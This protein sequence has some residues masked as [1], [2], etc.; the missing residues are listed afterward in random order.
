M[1][2]TSLQSEGRHLDLRLAKGNLVNV[3]SSAYVLG[4]F[5][6][7]NPTGATRF[8]DRMMG[9]TLM[10]LVQDGMLGSRLGEVSILPTSKERLLADMVIFVGLGPIDGFDSRVLE[11]VAE[12]LARVVSAA[13]LSSCTVVP[14]GSNA[15]LKPEESIESFLTGFLRGLATS[16]P[17]HEFQTLQFCERE[18]DRYGRLNGHV[19]ELLARGFFRDKGVDISVHQTT[20]DDQPEDVPSPHV[21][22]RQLD[23]LYL[24]VRTRKD[25]AGNSALDYC[26]LTADFGPT[27]QTFTRTIT[28]ADS[29]AA[30]KALAGATKI[31]QKLGTALLQYY[32]PPETQELVARHLEHEP[33]RHVVIIHDKGSSPIPWEVLH[34]GNCCPAIEAGL[35]RRFMSSSRMVRARSNLPATATVRVLLVANP[36]GDLHSAREEGAFLQK[37]FSDN[38]CVVRV[39]SE[40]EATRAN[41]LNELQTGGYDVLHYAGHAAFV[42]DDPGKSGVICH[43]GALTASDVAQ[44]TSAPQVVFLNGCE[45][46]RIRG[47]AS[48]EV[49]RTIRQVL[50]ED[51]PRAVSLAEIVLLGGVSNFIGTYWPVGDA[52]AGRFAT[53]FYNSLLGG[54]ALG[55]AL[56][57]ARRQ[58]REISQRDWANY[59]H[60]GNP[61][62]RLRQ[63]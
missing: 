63:R 9:G 22:E 26:V 10:R 40:R 37:L 21:E 56:R 4:V 7:I 6:N 16:D 1:S 2:A 35:S 44:V 62:Y 59:Q 42:A 31:D 18:A 61:S 32:M 43:D 39:L 15:G 45:S 20:A 12:N 50:Y 49:P 33:D 38:K 29:Q 57:Q 19:R 24:Q 51:L 3:Q 8:V 28:P 41:V 23:P 14:L 48:D 52:A 27:I 55:L 17:K 11:I 25:E 30:G 13:K 53:T 47:G 34:F 58:V 46:A 5:D 36:T 54:D 60:F